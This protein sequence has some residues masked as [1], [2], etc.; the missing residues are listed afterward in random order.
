[1]GKNRKTYPESF[2]KLVAI[3]ALE[4]K[5]TEVEVAGNYNISPGMVSRWK[6]AFIDGEFD[7]DVRR[8][9]KENEVLKKQLEATTLE[10]KKPQMMLDIIKKKLSH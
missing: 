1:M 9:K 4:G 5:K 8:I 3:E 6:N 2:K 10:I 7:G